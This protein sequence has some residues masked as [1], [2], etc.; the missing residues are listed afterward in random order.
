MSASTPSDNPAATT[1]APRRVGRLSRRALAVIVA[2][3]VLGVLG[4]GW[5]ADSVGGAT[6]APRQ[7]AL[8]KQVGLATVSVTPPT[9]AQR[10]SANAALLLHVTDVSGRAVVG[11]QAQ[12]VLSMPAMAMTLPT[13]QAETTTTPGVY[14]CPAQGLSPGAWALALTLVTS[15]GKTGHATF[16]FVVA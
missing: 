1:S 7:S 10:S 4:V 2:V 3:A 5:L 8:T 16:Q 12:C 13:A 9:T 11:A 15:D 6:S 14:R